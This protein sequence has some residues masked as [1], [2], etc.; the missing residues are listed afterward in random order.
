MR[1]AQVTAFIVLV[2]MPVCS[3]AQDYYIGAI[4]D[5]Q[6]DA[7][8]DQLKLQVEALRRE[9]MELKQANANAATDED[10]SAAAA[11]TPAAQQYYPVNEC[12]CLC[13]Q[14]PAPCID[15]PHVSTLSPY[16]NVS[17]FGALKTDMLY[18]SARAVAPGTPYFLAPNSLPGFDEDTFDLHAR[19]ST[20]GAALSGPKVGGFQ[21]GGQVA[22][23]FYDTNVLADQYGVLP[24]QAFG[25]LRNERWRFA[26]GLQF[27]VFNPGL[28]TI[29]PFSALSGSGNSG[30]GFRGQVRVERYFVT[31]D[32]SQRTFQFALSEPINTTVDPALGINED[33]G[34]PNFESR[35]AFAYGAL[36]PNNPAAV[37]PFEMGFSTVVGQTRNTFP[38]VVQVTNNVW[39]AGCDLRWRVNRC[40]GMAAEFYTGQGLGTY[41]GGILQNINQDTLGTTRS[42]GGW[43]ELYRYLTPCV[44]THF[45]MGI[46]DPLDRDVSVNPTNLGR[47]RNETYFANLIWDINKSYRIAFECTWRETHFRSLADNEGFGLHTQF[48]WSF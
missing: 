12:S 36:D 38:T 1:F 16:F 5:N 14:E 33:A 21:A 28:P 30:N 47:V 29:L 4:Q 27:D 9:V 17:I 26:A 37:R 2:F 24:L 6:G 3:Q 7:S 40:W 31:S 35:L 41:N 39:G 15:C 13:P 34:I 45:G 25:E 42:T 10:A 18:N 46:D 43:F 22:L 19:Q 11:G 32:C 44:H 23:I 20:L 48:Q 8:H